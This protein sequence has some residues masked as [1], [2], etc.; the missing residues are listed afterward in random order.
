VFNVGHDSMN[1]TKEDIVGLIGK[2]VDFLTHFAEI[3]TDDDKRN[4]EV[5]YSRIR[6]AGFEI[7]VDIDKGLDELIG[8]LRLVR[9][10]NPYSN[11]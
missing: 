6:D 10:Q 1:Y 8:A 9:F 7:E 5:D 11:V 2:R 4:Y 3:G